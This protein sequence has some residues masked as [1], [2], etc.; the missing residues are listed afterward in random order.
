M[1]LLVI[2]HNVF[3]NTT[4]M[5]KTM[6]G[7]FRDW[8]Q[9]EV[10]QLY[11]HSE[12]PV[13]SVCENYY[14]ITDKEAAVSILTRRCGRSF[15]KEDIEEKRE[16]SRTDTGIL[17]QIYRY[18][19]RRTPLIYM[20]RNAVWKMS[21]WNSYKLK[22][23]LDDFKPE[24][25]FFASGDYAFLYDIALSVA[26]NKNIPLFT[27]CMDDYYLNNVNNN[28]VLGRIEHRMFMRHVRK[29]LA[30]SS[31]IFT[32]CDKMAEDYARVYNKRCIVLHTPASF[33]GMLNGREERRIA[34]L[35]NLIP[36]REKSL[37]VL[38]Q[39]LKA[40]DL[41]AGP[42]FIDV[43]SSENR[44][45]VVRLLVPEN[46]IRFHGQVSANEVKRIISESMAVI[47]TEAFDEASKAR[48]RYS[49]STK[50]ADSL[51]SGTCLLVYAPEEIA[52]VD[53]LKKNNAAFVITEKD[54][55]EDKLRLFFEDG[56]VRSRIVTNA[57]Q[58]AK[59]NHGIT[60]A[61]GTIRN[62]IESYLPS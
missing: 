34:Y 59:C 38:G 22:R 15:G 37:V 61:G 29:T 7:Y 11:V 55:L 62:V 27:V 21:A 56:V 43:Y 35:G 18:A 5:G 39:A 32:L 54:D 14:R 2:S 33:D 52:S 17:S 23:W 50:I 58:L 10:A 3:S 51:A 46:G 9:H 44:A 12:V 30:Y 42:Q 45:E 41:P 19:Q 60:A 26:K 48:V 4:N 13:S 16:N 20:A 36:N 8:E 53:Y 1:R 47:H 25:V 28:S 24:A 49:V 40:L 31:A 6:L 57:L